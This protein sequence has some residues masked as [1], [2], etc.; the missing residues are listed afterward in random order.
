MRH[1]TPARPLPPI[2]FVHPP[3]QQKNMM[4]QTSPRA[5]NTTDAALVTQHLISTTTT[6][7]QNR[8]APLAAFTRRFSPDPLKPMAVCQIPLVTAGGQA[9]T[10]ATNFEDTTKFVGT[11]ANVEVTPAQITAGGHVTNAELQSGTTMDQWLEIKLG[12][13]SDAICDVVFTQITEANFGAPV[14]L[15]AAPL[16][17]QPELKLLWAAIAKA[18][19]KNC[20]LNGD[21]YAQFIPSTLDNFDVTT[22]G[23]P[24]WNNF[25]PHT[26]W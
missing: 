14:V 25:L 24:G 9:A 23:I 18:G 21:F 13:F 3:T 19:E 4:L 17:G 15:S 2:P 20:V 12:E 10:N 5:A 26:R 16:F 7:L 22:T 8:L 11:N 6:I 1:Y